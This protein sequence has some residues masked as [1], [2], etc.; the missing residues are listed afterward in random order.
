MSCLGRNKALKEQEQQAYTGGGVDDLGNKSGSF[1]SLRH[2]IYGGGEPSAYITSLEGGGG[3]GVQSSLDIVPRTAIVTEREETDFETARE[4]VPAFPQG[5]DFSHLK[6]AIREE[7]RMAYSLRPGNLLLALHDCF[8]RVLSGVSFQWGDIFKEPLSSKLFDVPHFPPTFAQSLLSVE[9]PHSFVVDFVL[10][11]YTHIVDSAFNRPTKRPDQAYHKSQVS[12]FFALATILRYA[13][14]AFAVH[15]SSLRKL[16]LWYE[17]QG[18]QTLPLTVWM[19][20]QASRLCS[21]LGL[22]SWTRNL[23]PLLGDCDSHSTELILRLVENI[24]DDPMPDMK[25]LVYIPAWHFQPLIPADSMEMLLRLRFPASQ[26]ATTRVASIYTKLKDVALVCEGAQQSEDALKEMFAVCLRLSGEEGNPDLAKEAESIAIWCLKKNLVAGTGS[27]KEWKDHEIRPFIGHMF[28]LS[29]RIA[30]EEGNPVLLS[31]EATAVAIW[32]LN[33]FSVCWK[34]WDRLCEE[35]L[36]G[37]PDVAKEAAA[38]SIWSLTENVVVCW[39]H[40]D[41]IYDENIE[42]SA[43]LLKMLVEKWKDH[44][45]KLLSS[46]SDIPTLSKTIKSFRLKNEQAIPERAAYASFHKVSND[47]SFHK[48]ADKSCKVIL[49]RL[50][51]GSS[52]L[53]GTRIITAAVTACII[54]AAVT[55]RSS[56][57]WFL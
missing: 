46:P 30:G 38:I 5:T 7:L 12:T 31:K 41:N 37:D 18:V 10:R 44:S 23:L 2:L 39:N 15:L 55:V 8:E 26:E 51:R 22:F 17:K 24:L 9:F 53:K 6:A 27:K 48:V 47:G 32:S 19:I 20:A 57:V 45:V 13:P 52:G 1:R 56:S 29:L 33:K 25:P 40:W 3:G 11:S 42:A 54:T 49:W 14:E 34:L 50:S 35:D 43:A 36:E 21:N 28:T 4:E 16:Q